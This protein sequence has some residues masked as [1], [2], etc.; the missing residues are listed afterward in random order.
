MILTGDVR[1]MLKT[2]PDESVH[3]S[4]RQAR[5]LDFLRDYY[6]ERGMPPTIREIMDALGISSPN[7]VHYNLKALLRLGYLRPVT[8]ATSTY[9]LPA[10]IDGEPCPTCGCERNHG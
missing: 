5:I 1:E 10:R 7:V 3:M 4:D 8:R 2:L 9:Y 6:V